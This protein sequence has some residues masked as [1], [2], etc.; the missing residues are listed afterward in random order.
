MTHP[1]LAI[2]QWNKSLLYYH[3]KCA[4]VLG[5]SGILRRSSTTRIYNAIT[6]PS[7]G[8]LKTRLGQSRVFLLLFSKAHLHESPDI[9]DDLRKYLHSI[10]M[11]E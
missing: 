2:S 7:L 1:L 6:S 9:T 8:E 5:S 11:L 3:I 10:R 4:S